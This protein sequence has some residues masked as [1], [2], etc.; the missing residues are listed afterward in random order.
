M[1][2]SLTWAAYFCVNEG[3]RP[4]TVDCVEL[5]MDE[6]V[7]LRREL[8]RCQTFSIQT[9]VVEFEKLRCPGTVPRSCLFIVMKCKITFCD[10]GTKFIFG[11]IEQSKIPKLNNWLDIQR[12]LCVKFAGGGFNA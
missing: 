2:V 8:P 1:G 11:A 10:G 12:A 7:D 3:A 4:D 9:V 6:G 5:P